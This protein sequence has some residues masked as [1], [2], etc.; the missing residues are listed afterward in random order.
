MPRE[1]WTLHRRSKV[2]D[3]VRAVHLEQYFRLPPWGIDYMRAHELMN[4]IQ[5]DGRT[6]LTDKDGTKNQALITTK[7]INEA[8]NF[9]P[10][11]YDFLAKTKSI[12]NNEKA[13]LKAKGNKYKYVDMV[14]SELELPFRLISQHFKVQKSPQI[15]KVATPHC[16]TT[17]SRSTRSSKKSLSNDEKTE[18][19]KE[20]DSGGSDK[21]E[22]SQKEAEA[23]GPSEHELSDEEDTST[24]LD[25]KSKKPRSAEQVLLDEAMA[26]VEARK[27]ALADARAT[28]KAKS[29]KPMTMEEARKIRLEKAKA[30]QE[31]RRQIEVEQKA[32]EQAATQAA[33]SAKSAKEKEVVDLT[34]T[35]ELMKKKEKHLEEQWATK[36]AREKIKEALKRKAEE[37]VLK[38][39]EARPLAFIS[40]VTTSVNGLFFLSS[41]G[42]PF[43]H[44]WIIGHSEKPSMA[45]FQS[46][47]FQ[48]GSNLCLCKAS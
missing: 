17:S 33:Q 39:R 2:V 47:F 32:Q 13:F 15:H 25:R 1:I 27:K 11:T 31:E 48:I 28:K 20:Q 43:S 18:T 10:G 22:D 45:K 29:T 4:S 14:Y 9:Y 40:R 21:E 36:L 24:P 37:P 26:R 38:L 16:N 30:L 41:R 6:L 42:V 44:W 12:D 7:V 46:K 34:G 3:P 8:L 23:K 35:I 19:D 5:Y